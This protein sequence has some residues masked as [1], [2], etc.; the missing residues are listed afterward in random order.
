MRKHYLILAAFLLPIAG[1]GVMAISGNEDVRFFLHW[2]M[3]LATLVGSGLGILIVNGIAMLRA[4]HDI[5]EELL[6][7]SIINLFIQWLTPA[8]QFVHFIVITFILGGAIL[9]ALLA[10]FQHKFNS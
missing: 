5:Y 3:L 2:S 1:H 10:W 6:L 9:S 4:E 7:F 8:V